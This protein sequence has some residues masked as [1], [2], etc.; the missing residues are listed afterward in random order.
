MRACSRKWAAVVGGGPGSFHSGLISPRA[1]SCTGGGAAVGGAPERGSDNDDNILNQY[2]ENCV[3]T[4]D[5]KS[6]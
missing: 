5:N 1:D 6:F 4:S 2:R 3:T